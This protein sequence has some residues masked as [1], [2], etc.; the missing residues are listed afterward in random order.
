M[1]AHAYGYASLSTVPINKYTNR[2]R[3][4]YQHVYLHS[5]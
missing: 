5:Y 1:Y 4:S 3:Y 2:Y